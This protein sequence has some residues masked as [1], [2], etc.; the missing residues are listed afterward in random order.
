MIISVGKCRL[1]SHT[2]AKPQYYAGHPNEALV[3]YIPHHTHY[4]CD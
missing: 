4:P 3:V 2:Q 1:H